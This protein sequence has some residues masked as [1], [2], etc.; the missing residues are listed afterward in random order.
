LVET[1][2]AQRLYHCALA[3]G[4]IDAADLA[5]TPVENGLSIRRGSPSRGPRP[6]CPNISTTLSNKSPVLMRAPG[7]ELRERYTLCLTLGGE[8]DCAARA[9]E[10]RDVNRRLSHA[11]LD[12]HPGNQ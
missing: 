10:W 5:L 8:G 12:V 7:T 2:A 9:R 11:A 3:V 1:G 6:A 4:A